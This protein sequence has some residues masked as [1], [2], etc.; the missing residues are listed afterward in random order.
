MTATHLPFL[1]FGEQGNEREVPTFRF[2]EWRPGVLGRLPLPQQEFGLSL[3]QATNAGLREL[4]EM[5]F[6][7]LLDLSQAPVTDAG[8]KELAGLKSLK[9]LYLSGT[10]VTDAGLPNFAY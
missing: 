10:Q 8:L 4:A 1:R 3:P 7:Q 9:T 2:R 5:D 6:L